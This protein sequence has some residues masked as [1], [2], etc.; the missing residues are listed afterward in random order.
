MC[1]PVGGRREPD[2]VDGLDIRPGARELHPAGRLECRDAVLHRRDSAAEAH[3]EPVPGPEGRR[4]RIDRL[5]RHRARIPV[6]G[7]GEVGDEGEGV[8]DAQAGLDLPV[9]R[10]HRS[11]RFGWVMMG[12]TRDDV[13]AGL[14][15]ARTSQS[16]GRLPWTR[17]RSS[18]TSSRSDGRRQ[19]H[20]HRAA[21]SADGCSTGRHPPP[22]SLLGRTVLVT[23]PDLGT[24]PRG[25]RCARRRSARGSCSSVAARRAWRPCA[26]SS[27][28]DTT[29]TGTRSWSRTWARSR[30]CAPRSSAVLA[31][32]TRL[33]VLVDNAGAIFPERTMGPDGIEATLATLVVGSVRADPR[34]DAA[35]GTDAGVAGHLGDLRRHVHT[36]AGRPRSSIRSGH[37]QRITRLR[38][39]QAGAGRADARVG[40]QESGLGGDVRGDAPRVGGHA[41]PRGVAARLP[42]GD[43][44]RCCAAR[45]RGPTPSSG[46]PLSPTRRPGMAGCSSTAGHDRSTGSP[47]RGCRAAERRELWDAVVELCGGPSAAAPTTPIGH[48]PSMMVSRPR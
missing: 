45:P 28:S 3:P 20:A 30:R 34:A 35:A 22:D 11:L 46:W 5:G 14:R 25:D 4:A 48:R 27:C 13:A 37:L 31:T 15:A 33:D 16:Q 41:G 17:D 29:T 12:V 1:V 47:R 26:T 23:G 6:H 42:P 24:W 32:E 39:R 36:A 44:A 10:G 8:V 40:P 2:V 21:P 38:P 9:Q 43:A 7:V 19:L 18:M